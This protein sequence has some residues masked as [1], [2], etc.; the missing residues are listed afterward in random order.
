M[1]IALLDGTKKND[2]F[3]KM[4][5]E[6][7]GVLDETLEHLKL[8]DM[9]IEPCRNCG[10][11]S[12]K[13]PGSCIVKDHTPLMM[14][15]IVNAE[16]FCVLTYISFGGYSSVTKKAM[17]K[18]VLMGL[19][20][21]VVYKGRLQH[22]NRYPKEN[23]ESISPNIIIAIIDNNTEVEKQNFEKLVK[24]NELIMRI[25]LQLVFV[26]KNEAQESIQQKLI[27]LFRRENNG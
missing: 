14:R 26:E 9:S 10:G 25:P 24:A 21:F 12:Y 19:P 1:S 5:V 4:L 8:E 18:L 11:C 15:C 2:S 22:P 27:E 17:D 16:R 13:T 7:L 23:L 20:N 3:S 6:S